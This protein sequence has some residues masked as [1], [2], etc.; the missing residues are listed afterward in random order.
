MDRR[1]YSAILLSGLALTTASDVH[2]ACNATVNGQPMS[3]ELCMTALQIYGGVEPGHYQL[4]QA[5]NWVN[6]SNPS[7]RGNLYRDAQGSGGGSGGTGNSSDGG[8]TR[9][10]FGSVGGGYYFNNETGA[11]VGP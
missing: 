8:L 2:A 7:L 10:P 6:L 3:M 9:T 5:G 4:D 11:S 1:F